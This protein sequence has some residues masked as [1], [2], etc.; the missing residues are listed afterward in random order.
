VNLS[1][2]DYVFICLIL[3]MIVHGYI[4]GLIEELFSW[5]SLVLGIWVAVILNSAAAAFI[6]EKWIPN[7]RV[8]PEILAFIAVFLI[9][10][11]VVKLLEKIL[12]EV[13]EGANLG[14]ANKVLGALFGLV[15]G[16]AFT[17]LII[18]VLSVQPLFDASRIFEESIFA[19]FLLPII[20]MKAG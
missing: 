20:R 17:L 12:K 5:A 14:T 3:L 7:I 6:R 9:V 19:R 2:I 11:I 18:F 16:L 15:E 8:I 1:V 4:K 10:M 13:V